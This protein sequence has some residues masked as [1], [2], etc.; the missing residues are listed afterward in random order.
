M[1]ASTATDPAAPHTETQLPWGVLISPP[2]GDL[3]YDDGGRMESPWHAHSAVILKAA[4]VAA[5]GGVMTDYYIG[6]NM[7]VYYSWK[8]IRNDEY[9]GPD[10]YVVKGVDGTKPRLYWAIWDEDGRYPDVIIELLS[11]GTESVDL[12]AKK[13]LYEQRFRTP[14][15]FCIAPEVERLLGWRLGPDMRYHPL[16]PN[17]H[18]RLWSEQLG[19]W[20]GPWRGVYLGEEHTWPRLFHA[21]GSLV[22]L[23]EEAERQRAEAER[24]RAEALAARVAALEEELARLRKRSDR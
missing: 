6:V 1:S 2:P 12:G 18:G 13:D 10:L 17:E 21:D 4:Y 16:A 9:R 19:F 23:P 22:L 11:P 3:P 5:H 15:Y 14:E 20:I 8:Q 24:Q 7:F